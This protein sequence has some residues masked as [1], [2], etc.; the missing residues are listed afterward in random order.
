MACNV[1]EWFRQ[2]P[3]DAPHPIADGQGACFRQRHSRG[4]WVRGLFGT[5]QDA[6]IATAKRLASC[7]FGGGSYSERRPQRSPGNSG[8]GGSLTGW[9]S[10]GW[11]TYRAWQGL[12]GSLRP[13]HAGQDEHIRVTRGPRENR[14]PPRDRS[15]FSHGGSKLP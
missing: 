6:P 2:L 9:A 8:L 12:C 7:A 14:Q 1:S 5:P 13:P 15:S 11:G 4:G 3:F 10:V